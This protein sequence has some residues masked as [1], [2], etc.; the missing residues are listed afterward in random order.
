MSE[1]T[2]YP[3]EVRRLVEMEDVTE[4]MAAKIKVQSLTLALSSRRV[5]FLIPP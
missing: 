1:G 5:G 2:S 3:A 4:P